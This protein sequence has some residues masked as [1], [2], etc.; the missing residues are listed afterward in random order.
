M[1]QNN[2]N[3]TEVKE[4][5]NFA[6]EIFHEFKIHSRIATIGLLI[7]LAMGI[8]AFYAND[9]KWR[10]LFS[11]YDYVSQDGEG[12][13][14]INTGEQGDLNNGTTSEDSEE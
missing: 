12:I 6:T 10:E 7:V 4:R 8:I 1:K 13:N 5:E 2:E 11:S 9:E 3:V 14:S